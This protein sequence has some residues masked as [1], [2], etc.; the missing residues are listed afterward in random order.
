MENKFA[1]RTAPILFDISFLE[2]KNLKEYQE[3]S[4]NVYIH[5]LCSNY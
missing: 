3:T 2:F 1:F 5:W 4:L